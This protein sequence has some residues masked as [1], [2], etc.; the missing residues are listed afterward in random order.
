VKMGWVEGSRRH[1]T[2]SQ[3]Q[4]DTPPILVEMK[5]ILLIFVYFIDF[6]EVSS[7]CGPIT[8]T[9]KFALTLEVELKLYLDTLEI[10]PL[11][12]KSCMKS[13][14]FLFPCNTILFHFVGCV[15]RIESM[16]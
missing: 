7:F 2:R 12:Q 11:S 10:I 4:A 14:T 15:C 9:W 5:N 13:N 8:N 3:Q 16:H 6:A 1:E